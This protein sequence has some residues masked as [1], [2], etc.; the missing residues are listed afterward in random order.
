VAARLRRASYSKLFVELFGPGLFSNSRLLVAEAMFAV[1]RYQ[2]EDPSFHPYTSKYDYWL[3]GKARLSSAETRGYIL[4]ND[5][6][7]ANCAGCH[8]D[9]P[10]RDGLPPRCNRCSTSITSVIPTRRR[11][12]LVEGTAQCG[13]TTMFLRGFRPT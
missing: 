9:Q 1:G 13:S 11:S 4:F 10:T 3:E 5:P 12:I 6:S 7:K 8:L 2:I